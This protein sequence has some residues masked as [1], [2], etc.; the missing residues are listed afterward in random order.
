ME[1]CRLFFGVDEPS[2][3][4]GMRRPM[5]SCPMDKKRI[6]IHPTSSVECKSWHAR[7]FLKLADILRDRGFHPEFVTHPSENNTTQWIEEHG[8]D[9]FSVDDLDGVAVRLAS[10]R[11]LIGNDS[12]IA[13]LASS[14]GIPTVILH[15]RRKTAIRWRP[16]WSDCETLTPSVPLVIR[17][18]KMRYWKH[19]IT[20]RQ[21]IFSLDRLLK[22]NAN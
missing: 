20:P 7:S 18:L 21:V 15:M 8:Y 19:F 14:I 1:M 6:M 4:N 16:A 22:L 2:I 5:A 12:G 10:A 9:R 3:D 11:A 13:H 17:Q